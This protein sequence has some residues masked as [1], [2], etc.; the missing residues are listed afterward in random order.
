MICRLPIINVKVSDVP[1]I[2][3]HLPVDIVNSYADYRIHYNWRVAVVFHLEVE[4]DRVYAVGD[5]LD[6]I[7]GK[8]HRNL[9]EIDRE[10]DG[11]MKIGLRLYGTLAGPLHPDDER[12]GPVGFFDIVWPCNDYDF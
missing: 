8:Q 2:T 11:Y 10:N 3:Q 9:V 5:F 7:S 4:G 1:E 6:T 12:T